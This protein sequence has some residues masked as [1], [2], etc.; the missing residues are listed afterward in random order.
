MSDRNF[1]DDIEHAL[2]VLLDQLRD[3][4]LTSDDIRRETIQF[5]VDNV[6]GVDWAEVEAVYDGLYPPIQLH[7]KPWLG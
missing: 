7:Q 4:P 3:Q 2:S 1:D 5:V 6:E